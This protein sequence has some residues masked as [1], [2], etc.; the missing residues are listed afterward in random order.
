M[1]QK[2]PSLVSGAMSIL[3]A[4]FLVEL[5]PVY[6]SDVCELFKCLTF[7]NIDWIVTLCNTAGF[8]AATALMLMFL[9]G[10]V[11]GTV[12]AYEKWNDD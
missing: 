11:I 1:T 4:F 3:C 10:V 9:A 12:V 7:S 8:L 5:S 6:V 2:L